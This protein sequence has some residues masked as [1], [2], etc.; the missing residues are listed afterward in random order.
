MSGDTADPDYADRLEH[1][2]RVWW[3][4]VVPVQLPY[5]L[6]LRRQRLGRTL[7]VGC[8]IGRNLRTL[9]P[10]SVGVDHNQ[11]A[12]T[13]ARG[14]GFDAMTVDE[15]LANDRAQPAAFDSILLAHVIEHMARP[16]AEALL[17]TYLPYLKTGGT[18]FFI[19]PQE[20][21]YA[22]DP[23]HVWFATG[24]DLFQLSRTVDLEPQRAWSFPFP[25][26]AGKFFVYNEFC[27]RATK[28]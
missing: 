24:D 13:Y 5:Q 12:V 1:A 4:R 26:R 6:H 10:G 19:C 15:F 8:G 28:P 25:R 17:R 7:D 22:S 11:A 9:G 23:T 3:K 18:V 21:G 20:R 27:V 16:D 14:L 2:Q